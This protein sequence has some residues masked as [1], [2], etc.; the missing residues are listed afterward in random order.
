M[1]LSKMK[2]LSFKKKKTTDALDLSHRESKVTTFDLTTMES[3]PTLSFDNSSIHT[4][5]TLSLNDASAMEEYQEVIPIPRPII[6]EEPAAQAC[7]VEEKIEDSDEKEKDSGVRFSVA[8]IRLYAICIGDNPSTTR[9]VPIALGWDFIEE[10]TVRVDDLENLRKRSITQLKMKSLDRLRLLKDE[11]YSGVEITKAIKVT[12]IARKRRRHTVS[13]LEFSTL[14]ER[15][16]IIWRALRNATFGRVSKKKEREFLKPYTGN[17]VLSNAFIASGE[18]KVGGCL[19][20]QTQDSIK[21]IKY[22]DSKI[23]TSQLKEEFEENCGDAAD[24]SSNASDISRNSSATDETISLLKAKKRGL[25]ISFSSRNP[26]ELAVLIE[27]MRLER[28]TMFVEQ[29]V[30]KI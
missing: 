14:H 12:N 16:E 27:S 19:L 26:E 18:Q 28:K 11:G 9:G 20:N 17:T 15:V 3:S 8:Q 23:S 13:S 2:G 24:S 7:F 4:A 6:I 22:R 29:G 30:H 10:E 5:K 25:E 21:L 1:L